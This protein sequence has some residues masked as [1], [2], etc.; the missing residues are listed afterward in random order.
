MTI[1]EKMLAIWAADAAA[2]ALVP[3]ARFK[4]PGNWQ[5]IARPYIIQYPVAE[6][7]SE[8]HQSSEFSGSL[9]IWEFYQ[10]SV[11]AD[12]YSTAKAVAE[13]VRTVFNGNHAGVQIVYR[14]QR[15]VGRDDETLTEHIAI[16]FRVAESL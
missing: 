8:T 16:D 1:E 6:A 12:S 14:G 11:I 4:V 3:A 13:K 2:T 15:F 7:A 10:L 5:D 9:R